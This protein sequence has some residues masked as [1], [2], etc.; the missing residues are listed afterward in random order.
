MLQ[1]GPVE[2]NEH[3]D[4]QAADDAVYCAG[5]GHLATRGRWAMAVNAAHEHTVFN[6][7]GILF[8]VLCFKEAPGVGAS[9]EAS[10]DFTWFKGYLWRIAFCRGCGAHLGWRFEGDGEPAVFFGLIKPK[11]SHSKTD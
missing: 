10:G 1:I 6:P 9:G 11:L 3:R 7:A 8:K 2:K 4:E 5:C